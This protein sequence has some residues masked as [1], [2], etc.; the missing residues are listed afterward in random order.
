VVRVQKTARSSREVGGIEMPKGVRIPASEV[1]LIMGMFYKLHQKEGHP[2]TETYKI[3]GEAVDRDFKVVCD[4]VKR[5]LPTT[6]LATAIFRAKAAD[7]AMKVVRKGSVAETI[8]ILE[9][10]NI[11]V[12]EPLKK[13]GDNGEG[14]FVLSVS[15]DSLGAVKVGVAVGA[16]ATKQAIE[17]GAPAPLALPEKATVEAEV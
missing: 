9:R 7:M 15:A 5:Y 13:G 12:L 4:V 8:N 17:A 11:G 6:D 16:G 14:G 2:L 10:P 3:I 1:S